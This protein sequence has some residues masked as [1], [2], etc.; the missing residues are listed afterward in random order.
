MRIVKDFCCCLFNGFLLVLLVIQLFLAANLFDGKILSLPSIKSELNDFTRQWGIQLEYDQLYVSSK[1]HFVV[2]NVTLSHN[3]KPFATVEQLDINPRLRTF[4]YKE[5]GSSDIIFFNA[6]ILQSNEKNPRKNRGISSIDGHLT[7]SRNAFDISN[8]QFQLGNLKTVI[9]SSSANA[10]PFSA[11]QEISTPRT[12]QPANAPLLID[13]ASAFLNNLATSLSKWSGPVLRLKLNHANESLNVS[14][15]LTADTGN[16][17]KELHLEEIHIQ[18]SISLNS[19]QKLKTPTAIQL[20]KFSYKPYNLL[21]EDISLTAHVAEFALSPINIPDF[22][23]SF[24]Q[25]RKLTIHGI[26]VNSSCGQ[27]YYDSKQQNIT[28]Q[29][30]AKIDKSPIELKSTFNIHDNEL[31]LSINTELSPS[32]LYS[33]NI[34]SKF[35]QIKWLEFP[36]PITVSTNIL[37]ENNIEPTSINFNLSTDNCTIK[38]AFIKK[39]HAKG[40]WSSSGLLHLENA[41]IKTNNSLVH[42]EVFQNFKTLDYKFLLHGNFHPPIINNWMLPWWK[43]LWDK[44]TFDSIMPYSDIEVSGKWKDR[45]GL[46]VFGKT[47]VKKTTYQ[48][49]YIPDGSVFVWVIPNY[50]ELYN[51]TIHDAGKTAKGDLA[52][53]FS[54]YKLETLTSSRFK[55]KSN[56]KPD[57]IASVVN[58]DIANAINAFTYT[59][60]PHLFIDATIFNDKA[61]IPNGIIPKNKL[62]IIADFNAPMSYYNTPF[63]SLKFN[64]T[65]ENNHIL[66]IDDLQF[67]YAFG[68]GSGA[69]KYDFESQTPLSFQFKV[70]NAKKKEFISNLPFAANITGDEASHQ[71]ND[72]PEDNA[73]LDIALNGTG[74]MNNILSYK[75]EGTAVLNDPQLGKIHIFGLLSRMLNILP[76][77]IGSIEFKK[78]NT[79]FKFENGIVN[80]H[81]FLLTSKTA[82]L[83]AVGTYNLEN[84]KLDF[85]A[86]MFLLGGIKIPVLKKIFSEINPLAHVLEFELKGN[87]KDPK[88]RFPLDPR[89]LF[90]KE[91][92]EK[93]DI[94]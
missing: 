90:K 2:K 77:S 76:F 11:F 1:F 94:R 24:F 28:S 71:A 86:K 88:W 15:N 5:W 18:N 8:L 45:S 23:E 53:V 92:E 57:N 69:V 27:I 38:K 16:P 6:S 74:S 25:A 9:S 73:Y 50:L 39:L 33:E 58:P 91:V 44:F 75:G 56:I 21:A 80:F 17:F 55:I 4:L 61:P 37:W 66:N 36:E 26:E 60:A 85:M 93:E 79:A 7:L 32:C 46:L 14:L 83:E 78:A 30:Y 49:F 54:P 65:L 52:W 89:N 84:K 87:L 68:K 40:S 41:R 13:Q 42:G 72:L 43:D 48:D 63:G 22:I 47:N 19:E 12:K 35:P 70:L 3:K 64:T 31:A 51:L 34:V 59:E 10:I 82:K 81:K 67:D 62:N 29:V 20:K